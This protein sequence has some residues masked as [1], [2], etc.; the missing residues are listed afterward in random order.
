[1]FNKTFELNMKKN[2]GIEW[3]ILM[4]DGPSED[5]DIVSD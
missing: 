5:F 3:S 4:H 1:M 2:R